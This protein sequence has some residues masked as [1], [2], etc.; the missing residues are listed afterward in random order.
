MLSVTAV[1]SLAAC[2]TAP[3]PPP[4]E[5]MVC[6]P[7]PAQAYIG[8]TATADV[9]E[10]ARKAAGAEIARTLK[11]GQVVTMEYR[12]GRLNLLVDAANV[13]TAARCG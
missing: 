1:L 5:R 13:I 3:T 11:P 9:M 10:A 2:T 6:N 12:D 8:K 7:A 4:S